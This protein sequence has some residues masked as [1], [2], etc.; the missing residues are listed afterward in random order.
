MTTDPVAPPG[1]PPGSSS[2]VDRVGRALRLD[3]QLFE[4]IEH[5]P[6]AMGQAVGVVALAALA[7][8]I[9]NPAV[10]GPGG[11]IGAVI[12]AM[13][14]WLF[15]TGLVYLAGVRMLGGTADYPELLRTLGFAAAPQMAMVAGL[16]PVVGLIVPLLVAFWGIAAYVIAVRQALDVTT[17]KAV[18]VC[19]IA[20]LIS[21]VLSVLLGRLAGVA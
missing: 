16:I 6:S 20:F 21:V 15:A 1:P 12:G 3:A 18:V 9:G 14:G 19:L 11:M 10:H 17:G 5:D 8:G 4:E 2:F 13:L 7:T